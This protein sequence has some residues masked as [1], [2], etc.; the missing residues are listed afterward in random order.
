MAK[1]T[2][3]CTIYSSSRA[4]LQ[5]I[6]STEHTQLTVEATNGARIFNR[7]CKQKKNEKECQSDMTNKSSSPAEDRVIPNGRKNGACTKLQQR[8]PS[9]IPLI[10]QSMSEQDCIL[11]KTYAV[12]CDIHTTSDNHVGVK[13]CNTNLKDNSTYID[14]IKEISIHVT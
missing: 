5:Y 4:K 3:N 6:S 9:G 1:I 8:R 14:N 11:L 10:R 13:L 2:C 12:K 7:K